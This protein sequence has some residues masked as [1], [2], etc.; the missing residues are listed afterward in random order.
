MNTSTL[1]EFIMCCVFPFATSV[2]YIF[3][4]RQN[5]KQIP[6]ELYYAAKVDGNSDFRYLLKVMIPIAK[7]SIITVIILSALGSSNAYIWPRT[8]AFDDKHF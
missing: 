6:N 4:L 5:F 2:F 7:P 3:F 8:V 1:T